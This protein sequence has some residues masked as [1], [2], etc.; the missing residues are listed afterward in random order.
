MLNKENYVSWSSRLLCYAKSRPNGKL[1][2]NSIINGPY[3]R[4]M[5]PEPDAEVK[6]MDAHDQAIQ[7]ILLGLPEDIYAVVDSCKTAQEIWF[8]F[9]DEESIVSYYHR[10]SNL[11]NDIKRNKHF[12]EKTATRANGIANENNGNQIRCYNYRGLGHLARNYTIRRKRRDATYLQTQLLISQKEEAGF[13]LQAEEFDLMDTT[14]N[15]DEIK[16]VN[17]DKT[18]DLSN[19]VTSNLVPTTKESKV[20]ENDKGIAPGMFQINP[21]NNSREVKS[22]PNK[23]VNAS[24]RINSITDPQPHVITKKVVNS[25]SHCYSFTRVDITTKTRRPQPRSN[26]KNDRVPSASK[27]SHIKNKQVELEDHLKNLLL[28]KNKKHMSSECYP[29]M[30]V[31][32]PLGLVQAYDRESKAYHQF[33]LEVFGNRHNLFSIGQFYDSDL[34]VAFRRNTCFV[35]NLEGVDLLKENRTTNLYTINPHDMASASLMPHGLGYFY[36]VVVMAPTFIPPQ[37]RHHK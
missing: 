17:V 9:T 1:V 33:C 24:V 13:Q 28:S 20:V 36:Q 15:L 4:R 30:F 32:R 18:N 25:D 35:R 16:E 3:V 37:L 26:I 29:N 34:D 8:T 11:M 19:P 12:P 6:Q 31:V 21:F 2:Y 27:S 14:A 5:I 10:F 7:T 23:L 22:V